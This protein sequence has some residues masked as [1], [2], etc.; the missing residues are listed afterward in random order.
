MAMKVDMPFNKENK[1]KLR[2]FFYYLFI[3]QQ[4]EALSLYSS[5]WALSEDSSFNSYPRRPKVYLVKKNV[6]R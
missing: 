1:P 5:R 2:F 6:V 3:V 4:I